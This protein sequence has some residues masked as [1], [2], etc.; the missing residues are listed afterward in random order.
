M[1]NIN[2]EINNKINEAYFEIE[3]TL[4]LFLQTL[5]HIHS[6]YQSNN[7]ILYSE[8]LLNNLEGTCLKLKRIKN[9]SPIEEFL[10]FFDLIIEKMINDK[11]D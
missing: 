3:N 1:S 8:L 9:S 4:S 7:I 2:E 6:K 10:M 11:M 5:G